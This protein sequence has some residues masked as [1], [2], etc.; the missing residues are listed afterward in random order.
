MKLKACLEAHKMD[1]NKVQKLNDL[2]VNLKKHN[3]VTDKED[4]VAAAETIY[5]KQNNYTHESLQQSPNDFSDLKKDVRKMTFALQRSFE[6]IKNLKGQVN[7]LEKE[8]NDARV[9]QLTPR[10]VIEKPKAPIPQNQA[11]Q[12]AKPVAVQTSI[13]EAEQKITSPIDR[14]GVA[15]S[16]VAIDKFFYYGDK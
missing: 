11:P 12:Q 8:L 16:D 7:R 4:A 9:N 2:A 10:K 6:E 5:G 13:P 3:I 15:P 14:N 1:I